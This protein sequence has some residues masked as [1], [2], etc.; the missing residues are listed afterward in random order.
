MLMETG[1]I[2]LL[3]IFLLGFKHDSRSVALQQGSISLKQN[4][5]ES[6]LTI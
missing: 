6:H 5:D 4:P 2:D 3:V 1:S